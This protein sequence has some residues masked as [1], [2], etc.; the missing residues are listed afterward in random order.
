MTIRHLRIFLE[1]S[2]LKSMSRAAE[3]MHFSQS[4]ISQAIKALEKHYNLMLFERLSKRLYIT[5]SG[6]KLQKYAKNV[7]EQFDKLQSVMSDEAGIEHIRFGAT[8]TC[9]CCILPQFLKDF[10]AKFSEVDIV[11]FIYNTHTVEENL[12]SGEIDVGLVEGIIKSKDLICTPVIDDHLVLAFNSNHEFSGKTSF[13]PSDL[14]GMDFVAREVGSGTR[15]LFEQYLE[16]HNINIHVTVEAPFPEAMRHAIINNNCLAVLSERLIEKDI[17]NGKISILRL[18]SSEWN[19]S[20]NVVYHKDKYLSDSINYITEL[21]SS[22]QN[23]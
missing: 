19:R 20:F 13:S 8:I 6:K 15:E 9:G 18:D 23:N 4:T 16:R 1:V 7:V 2:N 22:Y 5:E 21:L 3:N 10:G 12:L 17:A 11:S 14:S